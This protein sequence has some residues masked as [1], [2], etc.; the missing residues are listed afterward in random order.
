MT[1]QISSLDRVASL[2]WLHEQLRL[3][4][5][6]QEKEILVKILE[7]CQRLKLYLAQPLGSGTTG[8]GGEQFRCA[9]G[10]VVC[11]FTSVERLHQSI[12]E[13]R[14]SQEMQFLNVLRLLQPGACLSIDIGNDQQLCFTGSQLELLNS[15]LAE[16]EQDERGDFELAV[17]TS[18][19]HE[20]LDEQLRHQLIEVLIEICQNFVEVEEAYFLAQL[21]ELHAPAIV[22]LLC[23]GL[24]SERR[25]ELVE[26]IAQE[27]IRYFGSPSAIEVFDDLDI[28]SSRSWELFK[29]MPPIYSSRDSEYLPKV[30][31]Y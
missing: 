2:V 25:F 18:Q 12:P 23:R 10:G 7:H 11:C 17:Q 3:L 28:R 1:E 14:A 5:S 22:G 13:L 19:W 30:K 26:A 31:S 16:E 4:P 24:H 20:G 9:D 15:L 8:R 27:A 29:T 6:L 21:D